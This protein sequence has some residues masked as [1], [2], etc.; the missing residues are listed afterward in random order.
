MDG[1]SQ[2]PLA[3]ATVTNLAT[4]LFTLTDS[5]GHFVLHASVGD[6][7]TANYSGYRP[8]S[9]FVSDWSEMHFEIYAI[10]VRLPEYTLHDLTPFQRDSIELSQT[11]QKEL[12]TRPVKVGFSNANGGGF[13]GLIGAPIQKMSRSYKRNKKFKENFK[14]D[15]EQKFID[16]RY[17]PELVTTLT[18]FSGDSLIHFMNLY[19]MDYDFARAAS[20]LEIKGWIRENYKDYTGRAANR[21]SAGN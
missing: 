13:T 20:D 12:S 14:R 18:G 10:T 21:E 6:R 5:T 9:K 15:M 8:G 16:T 7:I 1:D 17:K 11:Y 3:D 2:R 4:G 19:P